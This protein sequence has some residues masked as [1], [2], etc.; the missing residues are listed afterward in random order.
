MYVADLIF[1]S[2]AVANCHL[3]VTYF[4]CLSYM[5]QGSAQLSS[6][7]LEQIAYLFFYLSRVQRIYCCLY[8]RVYVYERILF[9]AT[10]FK[11]QQTYTSSISLLSYAPN[12]IVVT[13]VFSCNIIAYVLSISVVHS[14][15]T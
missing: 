14:K 8:C 9:L 12:G 7:W 2:H 6:V 1:C 5:L 4:Y 3:V 10:L 15:T 13:F 11:Q